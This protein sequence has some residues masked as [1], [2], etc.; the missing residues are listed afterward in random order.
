MQL[1]QGTSK[2]TE[3]PDLSLYEAPGTFWNPNYYFRLEFKE[4]KNIII[5]KRGKLDQ[6]W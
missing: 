2:K 4:Q 6:L 1:N 5:C 3:N